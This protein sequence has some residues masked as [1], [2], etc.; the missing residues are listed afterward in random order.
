MGSEMC[1]RDSV[2]PGRTMRVAG[3]IGTGSGTRV[4]FNPRY[5]LIA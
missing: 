3:R 1:I 4:L 2:D 5:E